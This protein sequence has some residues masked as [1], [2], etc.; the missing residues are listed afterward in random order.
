MFRSLIYYVSSIQPIKE[1]LVERTY[2]SAI[3]NRSMDLV[4]DPALSHTLP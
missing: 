3:S 4:Y 2:P 1:G